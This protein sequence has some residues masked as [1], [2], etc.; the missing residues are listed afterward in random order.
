MTPLLHWIVTFCDVTT[1]L[2]CVVCKIPQI[3]LIYRSKSVEGLSENSLALE[4][5]TYVISLSYNAMKSY[6]VSTYMEDP[7]LSIQTLIVLL[8]V[9]SYNDKLSKEKIG[10][11]VG[12]AGV[13]YLLSYGIPHPLI[14]QGLLTATLPMKVFSKLLQLSQIWKAKSAG[15]ISMVSWG[16]NIYT[17]VTRIITT[18]LV[19]ND[20]TILIKHALSVTL[21]S[22]V[23]ASAWWFERNKYTKVE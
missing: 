20:T 7:F 2:L 23:I 22:A 21:N 16:I 15:S 5:L 13:F 6:P 8:I 4:L 18:V 14:L 17:C 11:I 9:Y 12:L 19:T 3:L 10:V 1:V